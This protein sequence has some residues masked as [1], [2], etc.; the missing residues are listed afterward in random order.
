MVV[1]IADYRLI[2]SIKYRMQEFGGTFNVAIGAVLNGDRDLYQSRVAEL[3]YLQAP[4]GSERA[5][6]ALSDYKENAKQALDRITRFQSLMVDYPAVTATTEDFSS[7]YQSWLEASGRTFQLHDSGNTL[8]ARTQLEGSS[9][10]AFENLRTIYDLAGQSVADAIDELE[11]DALS[12]ADAQEAVILGFGIIVMIASISLALGGPLLMSRSLRQ[13]TARI[14]EISE[15]DGDLTA[16]I[17]SRRRDEIGD[18]ATQFDIF[19]ARIDKLLQGVRNSTASVSVAAKEIATSSDDLASRTEQSASNLQETSASMEQISATVKNTADSAQQ[20]SRLTQDTVDNARAGQTTMQSVIAT[21]GDIRDSSTRISEIITM[22]DSIAFQTNILA[23]NASVEAARAGEH[24]RGFAVVAQEVRILASRSSEASNEIRALIDN[25][26]AHARN[27]AELVDQAGGAMQQIVQSVQHVNDV[28]N[29][30]SAGTKEQS[31]G[32]GQVNT[33][34][35]D[36]DSMTQHNASM[37]EQSR[38]AASEMRDQVLRLDELLSSFKLSQTTPP[39][40]SSAR[41]ALPVASPRSNTETTPRATQ[42]IEW[43]SF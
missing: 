29:E 6:Q 14:K 30:I 21:M 11:S 25:S 35:S 22:I 33:A 23:L 17:T 26:V 41:P 24:G 13:I 7:N 39:T 19:I 1:Y 9:L 2:E 4:P 12:R 34:V 8:A 38:A 32:I 36:L 16:R 43:E 10:N 20:A 27:G 31:I 15:G 18:L 3:E 28:I 42:E 5:A 40:S 37:V